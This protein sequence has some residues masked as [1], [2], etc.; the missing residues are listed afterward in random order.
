VSRSFLDA[1]VLVR[2]FDDDEPVLQAAARALVGDVDGPVLVTSAPVLAEFHEAVTSRMARPLA[3]LVA[4]RVVA[5][6]A[7]LTVV[8]ADAALVLAA[9]D[10]ADECGL[11]LRDALTLEAAAVGGCDR[12]LTEALPHGT[13]VRGL[14]VEDPAERSAP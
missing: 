14:L 2:L 8:A 6:L 3:P 11:A 9:T 5:E 10:T 7:D 13:I 4:R 12:V 1:S